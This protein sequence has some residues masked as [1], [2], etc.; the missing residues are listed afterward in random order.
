MLSAAFEFFYEAVDAAKLAWDIDLLRTFDSADSACSASVS[1]S[2]ARNSSVVADE[3]GSSILSILIIF[4]VVVDE[5]F[6][7]ALVV[8]GED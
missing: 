2:Q 6:V 1:L 7:H 8:V 5:T 3:I 4:L